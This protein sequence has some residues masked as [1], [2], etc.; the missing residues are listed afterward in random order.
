M[1]YL[2]KPLLLIGL[3]LALS[4]SVW[5]F[6]LNTAQKGQIKQNLSQIKEL[7]EKLSKCTATSN[8]ISIRKIKGKNATDISQRLQTL[9]TPLVDS[10]QTLAPLDKWQNVCDTLGVVAWFCEMSYR[11]RQMYERLSKK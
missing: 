2:P 7:Q 11:D 8:T 1:Q 4:L 10:L 6:S 3:I 9:K 5:L